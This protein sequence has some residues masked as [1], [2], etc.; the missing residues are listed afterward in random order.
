MPRTRGFPHDQFCVQQA[1]AWSYGAL[2]AFRFIGA[3]GVGGASVLGPIYVAEISPARY[4]GR[5][6]ILFQYNDYGNTTSYIRRAFPWLATESGI[7]N[8]PPSVVAMISWTRSPLVAS[9]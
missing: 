7:V 2:V 6:V 3:L 8:A 5:R 1:L 9:P 4:R